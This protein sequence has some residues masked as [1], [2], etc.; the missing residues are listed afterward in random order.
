M[1]TLLATLLLCLVVSFRPAGQSSRDW[2]IRKRALALCLIP[3][4][5]LCL[6]A[7]GN[8]RVAMKRFLGEPSVNRMSSLYSMVVFLPA[9]HRSDLERAG[10]RLTPSEFAG[11]HL[12]RY[13]EREAQLWN[14]RPGFLIWQMRQALATTDPY[15][16]RLQV[17]ARAVMRSALLHHPEDLLETYLW[18]AALYLS[19]R[20]WSRVIRGELGFELS[21]PDWARGLLETWTGTTL[22]TDLTSR[23]SLWPPLIF[24]TAAF[25]PFLLGSG[26]LASLRLLTRR[27]RIDVDDLL[28]AAMIASFATTPLY[29]HAVKPR[30]VLAPVL[31]SAWCVALV[32]ATASEARRS[33]VSGL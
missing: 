7:E 9:L 20:E 5:A 2:R 22:P 1:P 21:L 14:D 12:E 28:A 18:S 8:A 32:L 19:P 26:L 30:Y 15:D 13:D 31:L 23:R 4:L 16:P 6:L 29:S 10:L 24:A 3:L 25:Y 17:E 27:G 33:R 11:L